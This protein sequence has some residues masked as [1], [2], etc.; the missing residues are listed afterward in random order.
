MDT[1]KIV[2]SVILG[3]MIGLTWDV[4]NKVMPNYFQ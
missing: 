3:L 2:R 1:E 4:L